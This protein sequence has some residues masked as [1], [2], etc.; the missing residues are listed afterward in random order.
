MTDGEFILEARGLRVERAGTTVLDV[1]SLAV[2]EGE[3]LT[4]IGP[5]RGRGK[6]TLLMTLS[7]LRR[8]HRGSIFFQGR[9]G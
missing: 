4:F 2:A 5:E 6:S 9:R 3:V 1:P 8:P 7:A